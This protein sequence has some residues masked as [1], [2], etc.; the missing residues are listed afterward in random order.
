MTKGTGAFAAAWAGLILAALA[1]PLCAQAPAARQG[2]AAVVNG[3]AI[4][5]AEL[6]KLL[7]KAPPSPNPLTQ[8]QKQTMEKMARDM[9]IDDALMRQFLKASGIAVSPAAVAKEFDDLRQALAKNKSTLEAFLKDTG[10]TEGQLRADVIARLQWRSYVIARVP[11]QELRRY[12]DVNKVFFDKVYVRCSHILLRVQPKATDAEKAAVRARLVALRQDILAGKV[13]FA[14]AAKTYSDCPSKVNGGD[15]GNVPYKFMVHEAVSKAAFA[16]N[17]GD[18]SDIIETDFGFHILK[19]TD[20][21]AG[22][23]SNYEAIK[24]WVRDVYVQEHEMFQQIIRDQRSKARI[25]IP[26]S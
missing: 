23:P 4:P 16:L 17:K 24:D 14:Q 3:E 9:L 18:V 15:I 13:D 20:R 26:A 25:E 8:E 7:D 19:V 6:K 11:E 12:Y 10:Q 22:E 21:T 2:P 1:G 5:M